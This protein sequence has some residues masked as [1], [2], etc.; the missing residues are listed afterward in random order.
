MLK[1]ITIGIQN[2]PKVYAAAHN[3]PVVGVAAFADGFNDF[4]RLQNATT[5][6]T[7][8]AYLPMLHFNPEQKSIWT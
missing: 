8:M 4:E 3:F 6:F 2:K 7:G 1:N 5:A